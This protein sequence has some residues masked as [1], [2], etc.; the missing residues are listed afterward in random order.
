MTNLIEIKRKTDVL[1]VYWALTDFCNFRCSYCPRELHSGAYHNKIL[2]GFPTDDEIRIFLDRLINIHAKD[3]FLVVFL[4]GGEPTLH[5]MYKEIVNTLHPHGI[6]GTVSNGSRSVDWWTELNHLPDIMVI[7][8]HPEWTK[9]NKI[10]EL[11]E[12]L[13]DNEVELSFNMMSDN[14]KWDRVQEM[15]QQLTPR[16]QALVNAK[17]LTNQ[18]GG[19]ADGVHWDYSPEQLE[20]INNIHAT[21]KQSRRRFNNINI[22]SDIKYSDGTV[23]ELRNPFNLINTYQ[24]NFKGWECNAG[25]TDISITYEGFAYS[26]GCRIKRLGRINTFKLLDQP[27]T[28][29]KQWCMCIGDI[30]ISKKKPTLSPGQ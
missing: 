18:S 30:S 21:E 9:I 5:P 14:T 12:F 10:N 3:K 22:G 25:K 28:C 23:E 7:S 2:T 13:L 29:P 19:I 16:L 4:S 6:V 1:Y 15:Y 11:G 26:A 24:H 27:I 17:V 20:Y 8:L